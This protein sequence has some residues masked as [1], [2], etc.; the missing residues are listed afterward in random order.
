MVPNSKLSP[1]RIFSASIPNGKTLVIRDVR[2][3]LSRRHADRG[4]LAARRE[5]AACCPL[6]GRQDAGAAPYDR[7]QAWTFRT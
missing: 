1:K 7:Q 3:S 5:S 2:T 6:G 4:P